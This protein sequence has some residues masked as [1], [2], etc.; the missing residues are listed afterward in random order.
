M[1][2]TTICDTEIGGQA[3]REG[4]KVW[5]LYTSA[6]PDEN[7]FEDPYRFD[8]SRTPNEQV[9]FGAGAHFCLGAKW[10]LCFVNCF[11]AC[12]TLK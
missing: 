10:Q 7:T 4:E 3:L 2:R 1:R 6:K 9:G 12:R 11:G 5:L 8:I